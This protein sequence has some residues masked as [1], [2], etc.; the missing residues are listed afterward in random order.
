MTNPVLDGGRADFLKNRIEATKNYGDLAAW[1]R[2]NKRLSLVEMEVN[3]VRFST[4]NHR[5]KAEQRREIQR[6]Q[7]P[8]LFTQDPLGSQAQLAQ[9]NILSSQHGFED[10]KNDI[11]KRGQQEPAVIT[12]EGV[13]INGNRRTAALRSLY[14]GETHLAARYVQCLVLPEDA[15]SVEIIDLE[16]ELQI[17][18]DFKEGYSWIN[19]ALLIEELF[20][21]EGR[22]F[23]RLGRKMHRSSSDVRSMYEKIQ[24]VNQL[25]E[26]SGGTRFHLDFQEHESAFDE[27]TTY[28][29]SK[30]H[31]VIASVRAAYF[32]GTLS[33]V[34][35]RELRNLRRPDASTLIV[36]EIR[37]DATIAPI[38][39]IVQGNS[40]EKSDTD[41]L[42]DDV[43]G[44]ENSDPLS[45]VLS[46]LAKK[47]KSESIDLPGSGHATVDDILQSLR[48]K[49]EAAAYE[50]REDQR[51]QN[52]LEAPIDRLDAAAAEVVRAAQKLP[53]ARVMVGWDE[54]EFLRKIGAL[55]AAIE[56]LEQIG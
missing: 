21:S 56:A 41:G 30:S 6:H 13:L 46:Y 51:D 43:L 38:L 24:Q 48:R 45:D 40:D 23:E 31:E 34:T 9:F 10:L 19:E 18:K 37:R 42:L 25:V 4:L 15:T 32:L 28:I 3:W 44:V 53:R 35:Y 11:K 22:D 54:A 2:T 52:A 47:E 1:P 33:G 20:A 29:K 26:L 5:T 7:N 27:L 50:A 55:K 17:A 12:A 14:E 8:G 36:Q 49:I 16:T 39:D